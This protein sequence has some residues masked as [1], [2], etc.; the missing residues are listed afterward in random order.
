MIDKKSMM[1]S[2]YLSIKPNDFTVSTKNFSFEPHTT[3]PSLR[4]RDPMDLYFGS[5]VEC[6]RS[7]LGYL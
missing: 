5:V 3:F 4:M 1:D 7:P 6:F 2:N